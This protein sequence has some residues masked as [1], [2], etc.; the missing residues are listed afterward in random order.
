VGVLEERLITD[1]SVS[2]LG[3]RNYNLDVY[4]PLPTFLLRY[5]NRGLVT[6]AQLESQRNENQPQKDPNYHQVDRIVVQVESTDKLNTTSDVISRLLERRHNN[7]V[8]FQVQI[9]EVLLKQQQRTKSIFNVV[10]GAIAGISLL[11]GG[12]G[13]MNIMLA[14]VLERIK[15]IGIRLAVGA[16]KS[17]IVSQFLFESVMISVTGGII[18]VL[19]GLFLSNVVANLAE[20]PAI[21]TLSSIAFAFGVSVSVG[22]IFGIAPARKAAS[23]NP[24][25]SLRH[26]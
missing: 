12:I 14:S 20:I 16:T 10:L 15:E 23:Q 3:I 26:E 17:D 9:P 7:V 21:I 13:I 25:E 2:S 8:D 22:L 24:I 6:K 1:Q 18:G 19:L 11:V 4:C 5:K